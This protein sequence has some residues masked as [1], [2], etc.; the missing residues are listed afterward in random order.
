MP[1]WTMRFKFICPVAFRRRIFMRAQ[2]ITRR[3]QTS[4]A[5]QQRASAMVCQQLQQLDLFKS[6]QDIAFYW[7][8]R[9]EIDARS[10]INALIIENKKCYLPRLSTHT[11]RLL[12]FYRYDPEKNLIPNQFNIPEPAA[13]PR[14]FIAT[15]KLDIVLA[16]LVAFDQ[17]NNRLGTGCGYYDTTFAFKKKNSAQ[18]PFLIGL[19]YTWQKQVNL[20]QNDWDVPM[21]LI[22]AGE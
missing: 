13:D 9:G 22:C 14:Y 17:E 16:P 15:Q 2:L 5:S 8:V 18:K 4:I 11:P 6:A 19:A 3:E 12:E 7:P 10:L 20:A 1:T 21:D